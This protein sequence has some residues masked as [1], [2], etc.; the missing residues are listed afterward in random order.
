MEPH[1][2]QKNLAIEPT[3]LVR[4]KA[5]KGTIM[6]LAGDVSDVQVVA[7]V[8]ACGENPREIEDVDFMRI[9]IEP[10]G[11]GVSVEAD[12]SE[13]EARHQVQFESDGAGLPFVRFGIGMPA[14]ASLH[15]KDYK[16]DIDVRGVRGDLVIDTYKGEGSL[17]GL[18]GGLVL[19]TY[20]GDLRIELDALTKDLSLE[21]YKGRLELTIPRGSSFSLDVTRGSKACFE[22]DFEIASFVKSRSGDDRIVGSVGSGGPKI[23]FSTEKGE[24]FLKAK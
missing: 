20:K 12:Y 16:S 17:A 18:G 4:V 23:R 3:G 10:A 9:S 13:V 15:I 7:R 14:T 19:Q 8:E 24:L 21:T 6:V 2:V 5:Y 11:G 22:S 1:V